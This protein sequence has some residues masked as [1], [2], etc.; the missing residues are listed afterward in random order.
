MERQRAITDRT[1]E[2]EINLFPNEVEWGSCSKTDDETASMSE[3]EDTS[4][5]QQP[6]PSPLPNE[7]TEVEAARHKATHDLPAFT[8]K[9]DGMTGKELLDHFVSHRL[10]KY[11]KNQKEVSSHPQPRY[12]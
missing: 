9:P 1:A 6:K 3:E 4:C 5:K 12:D 8:F 7:V 11:A 2:E 10:R